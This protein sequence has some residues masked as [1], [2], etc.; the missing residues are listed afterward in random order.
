MSSAMRSMSSSARSMSRTTGPHFGSRSF[1]S[2]SGAGHP[3]H[4]R[5]RQNKGAIQ[6][7]FSDRFSSS[8]RQVISG[9]TLGTTR[10]PD[11]ALSLRKSRRASEGGSLDVPVTNCLTF[12]DPV[13]PASTF[14]Q[15]ETQRKGESEGPERK[16]IEAKEDEVEED[17]R[18]RRERSDAPDELKWTLNTVAEVLFP[19][20]RILGGLKHHTETSS[21]QQE[22]TSSSST[23]ESQSPVSADLGC[24]VEHDIG[25]ESMSDPSPM[26]WL[27]GHENDRELSEDVHPIAEPDSFAEVSS[28][29]EQAVEQHPTSQTPAMNEIMGVLQPSD[30]VSN[31]VKETEVP[32]LELRSLHSLAIHGEDDV[33]MA[34]GEMPFKM[35]VGPDSGLEEQIKKKAEETERRRAGKM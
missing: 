27:T 26:D 3:F 8:P 2:A 29:P 22:I 16:K 19:L 34:R 20:A 1:R 9:T 6:Q 25:Q 33:S 13:E 30:F 35:P 4:S 28:L 18:K 17:V 32:K 11:T 12:M 15:Q 23:V 5:T 7:S 31:R 14:S 21:P 24:S 10:D